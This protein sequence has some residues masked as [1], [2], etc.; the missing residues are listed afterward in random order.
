MRLFG[1]IIAAGAILVL[2][3][4]KSDERAPSATAPASQT[5]TRAADSA[6]SRPAPQRA[7]QDDPDVTFCGLRQPARHVVYLVDRSGSM[8]EM[9]HEVRHEVLSSIARLKASQTFHVIFFSADGPLENPPKCLVPA[10]VGAKI[11]A[12]K[13]LWEVAPQGRSDSLP[14]IG[15]AFQVLRDAPEGG[16][17]VI[18]LVTDGVFPDNSKVVAAIADANKGRAVRVHTI[19]VGDRSPAAEKVL[20]KIAAGNGGLFKFVKMDE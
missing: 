8:L 17:R 12:S 20:R 7:D 11:A 19:L 4:C 2:S 3:G 5:S 10:D 16:G 13:F 9:F 14:A 1:T 15:R 18:F 6:A